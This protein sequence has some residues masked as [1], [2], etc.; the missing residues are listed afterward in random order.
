MDRGFVILSLKC[1]NKLINK[2]IFISFSGFQKFKFSLLQ[3]N[4]KTVQPLKIQKVVKKPFPQS[5][6]GSLK[7]T[8]ENMIQSKRHHNLH[9]CSFREESQFSRE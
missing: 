1:S 7:I 3:E 5:R 2:D 8:K 9:L 4:S 6:T